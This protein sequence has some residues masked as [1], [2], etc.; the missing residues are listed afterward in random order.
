MYI[1]RRQLQVLTTSLIAVL[2]YTARV[3]AC[4]CT[5]PPPAC[6]AVGQS[7]LVFLGTV[8]EIN[9]Q[10]GGFKTARMN[11]DRAYKGALQETLDLFDD[12][13]CD[14]PNLTVGRQYLMYTSGNPAGPV[15]ARGCTRSRRVEDAQEDLQFLNQYSV[16]N[17]N[18]YIN[19]TI[20]LQPDGL[21]SRH[22]D[23]VGPM[24]LNGVH[25]T[26]SGAGKEFQT[27][28]DSLGVYSFSG[29]PPGRYALNADLS[30][31]RPDRPSNDLI[32]QSNGCV[33]ANII[34]K[35]D[36]RVQGIIRDENN[37][38]V[39]GALVE[40][41]ST[42]P[43]LKR[44]EQPVLLSVSDQEGQYF[45]A[46]I[47]PGN[48]YLGVN[49]DSAP[50]KEHPYP[51]TY[52]PNTPDIKRATQIAFGIGPSAYEFDLRLPG[53]LSLVK[54][55]GRIVNADGTPP[56]PQDHPQVRFKKPD[57]SG[58]IEEESI[59]VDAD[60]RFEFELCEGVRYGAFAFS[61]PVTKET[62]SAPLEFI[63]TKENNR[64]ELVL[65]K[66]AKEFLNL[67]KH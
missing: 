33:Q 57:L 4:S 2:L 21:Q 3:L 14:G 35:V 1:E 31:Y 60:G 63:P 43:G 11:I 40:M 42:D 23:A 20:G 58:Q 17:I 24:P 13:M 25:V 64:L 53:K 48:Y 59:V 9:A 52:Y 16:G 15:P 8:T 55:E 54:I 65:D 28:T 41:I 6:Q 29:L 10:S 62:Y 46:G 49:I 26:V 51:S 30:G 39:D 32:L 50:K 36:R 5:P 34:M 12:G 19:G 67:R 38:P 37:V 22:S 7:Q 66:T 27:S 56:Q 45:I 18:T 61:G 47:P 44:W